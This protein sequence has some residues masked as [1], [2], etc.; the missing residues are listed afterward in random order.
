MRF[1]M[2]YAKSCD[3][4][5]I[6]RNRNIAE[7]QKPCKR[8]RTSSLLNEL[9]PVVTV[10]IFE[11]NILLNIS[12]A[13][14]FCSNMYCSI[15]QPV[16]IKIFTYMWHINLK[17][18]QLTLQLTVCATFLAI[19][20]FFMHVLSFLLYPRS[21]HKCLAIIGRQRISHWSWKQ[22]NRGNFTL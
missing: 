20:V 8:N 10:I 2:N 13:V 14:P 4:R 1:L 5:S 22:K 3:L 6:M 15:F 9:F 21:I 17:A 18:R 11:I 16:L 12:T 7:Y 19:N